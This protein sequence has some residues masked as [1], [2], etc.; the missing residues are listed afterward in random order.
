M[1]MQIEWNVIALDEAQ[2]IKNPAAKRSSVVKRLRANSCIA[3]TGTPIENSLRDLWSIMEFVAS[4]YLPPFKKFQDGYPDETWAAAQLGTLIAPLVIRRNV[5]EVASD[6]PPRIDSFVPLAMNSQMARDYNEIRQSDVTVLAKLT[7]LRVSA[8]SADTLDPGSKMTRLVEIAAEAF[9]SQK[10]VLV[11]SSFASSIDAI[12]SHFQGMSD[13]FVATIDGRTGVKKR[14]NIIDE[15]S[16]HD[17]PGILVLNPRAAGVGLNIQAA[18]YVV[19]FTPEWNPAVVDQASARAHRRG[20]LLPVVIYYLFYEESVE[21]VMID[22]LYF[23]RELQK[24][25]METAKEGPDKME[26]EKILSLAPKE[27]I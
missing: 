18:S 26:L 25:G 23:K 5:K 13:V 2:G 21:S 7:A 11:F 6:L 16:A 27:D 8:A 22:R 17:G 10:K 15:Y 20:Q 1:F 3:V 4:S 24:S 12:A 14:Q 19:H 9:Q